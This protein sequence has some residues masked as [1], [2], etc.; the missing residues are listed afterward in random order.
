MKQ[1]GPF[2][3]A[4]TGPGLMAFGSLC[5]HVLLTCNHIVRRFPFSRV[6]KYTKER[7]GFAE[8]A[9]A[10]VFGSQASRMQDA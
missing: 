1:G 8:F 5:G 2:L 7:R 10:A 4:S 3:A 6:S 9:F